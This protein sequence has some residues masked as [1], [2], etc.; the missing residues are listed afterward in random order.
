MGPCRNVATE[1][2]KDLGGDAG[3]SGQPNRYFSAYHCR[4][5]PLD[6]D[7]GLATD[8]LKE[9]PAHA[10]GEDAASWISH[11]TPPFSV[12]QQSGLAAG[13]KGRERQQL[14][15]NGFLNEKPDRG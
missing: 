1:R 4:F 5:S 7:G 11:L 6:T 3:A 12:F 14:R 10:A 13:R 8:L 9:T 2:G 15:I